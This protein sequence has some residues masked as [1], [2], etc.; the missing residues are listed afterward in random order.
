MQV[1]ASV[2][3]WGFT[4]ILGK[5]IS[6][7]AVALVWWR[8]LIVAVILIALPRVWRALR[9][10]PAREA[11]GLVGI[12]AIIALHWLTFYASIK[13][14]NA[15]VAATCMAL[16]AVF[17]ALI[18]PVTARR[19]FSLRDLTIGIAAVPGVVLV[20]GS[21][22]GDMR[23]G[24]WVGVISAVLS[25]LFIVLNKRYATRADPV[26][27]TAAEMASGWLVVTLL[28]PLLA[29]IPLTDAVLY[30][31]GWRDAALL[32]VLAVACTIVP[33]MW[34]LLALRHVSAFTLQLAVNLE[35]IYAIVLAMLLLGEH[36]ELTPAF[37]VGVAIVVG[38][39]F[40]EPLWKRRAAAAVALRD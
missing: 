14:A 7:P 18:E 1:H 25:A 21:L 11:L 12:G 39:V 38:A 35:P 10:M 6:L 29:V 27:V 22:P 30:V 20:V 13:L 16:G 24:F 31:P 15:S 26:A 28:L 9:S 3:L 36:R 17:T 33:F 37:Y 23:V 32:L 8:M 34:S 2:V 4:A 5:L 19:R 40:L